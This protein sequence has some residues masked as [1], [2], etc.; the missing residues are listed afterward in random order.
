MALRA[1]RAL[2]LSLVVLGLG[3]VADRPASA[4]QK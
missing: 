1:S 3:P 4:A 2:V